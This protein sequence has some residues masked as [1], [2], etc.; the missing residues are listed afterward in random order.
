M[1]SK[2]ILIKQSATSLGARP[3][4]AVELILG[5]AKWSIGSYY[6]GGGS[7]KIAT[8]LTDSEIRLLMPNLILYPADDREFYKAVE[9]YFKEI[10]STVDSAGLSLEVGL[11]KDN[12]APVTADNMP[13]NIEHYVKYRHHREHPSVV[14]NYTLAKANPLARFYV[15][16]TEKE[17][18]LK[19]IEADAQDDAT[20]LYFE[21]KDDNARMRTVLVLMSEKLASIPTTLDERRLAVKQLAETRASEFVKAVNDKKADIKVLIKEGLSV[22]YLEQLSNNYIVLKES[23]APYGFG[24]DE[25]AT[26]LLDKKNADHLTRLKNIVTKSVQ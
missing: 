20:K 24:L 21:I 13:L 14:A 4:Q 10:V 3:T 19:K 17:L 5:S 7:K 2:V 23:Q 12:Y 15:Q 16:D 22:G 9:Q 18:M 25:T 8:G 6:Q 1:P 11:E 26:Y